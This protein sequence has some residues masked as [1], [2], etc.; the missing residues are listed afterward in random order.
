MEYAVP[1]SELIFEE[2]DFFRSTPCHIVVSLP[3]SFNIMFRINIVLSL[4]WFHF[5][6]FILI[7]EQPRSIYRRGYP[8]GRTKQ[9]VFSPRWTS[10][11]SSAQ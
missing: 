8:R 11:T 2:L 6:C 7:V 10:G 3:N 9:S 5:L 4:T 1:A